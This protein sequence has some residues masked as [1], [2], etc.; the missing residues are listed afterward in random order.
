MALSQVGEKEAKRPTIKRKIDCKI[1]L[2]TSL[3]PLGTDDDH[4]SLIKRSAVFAHPD[5]PGCPCAEQQRMLRVNRRSRLYQGC[6]EFSAFHWCFA[7]DTQT[8]IPRVGP[9]SMGA[10]ERGGRVMY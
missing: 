7:G 2:K 1:V 5:A 6:R 9:H 8:L 4:A 3:F 10:D